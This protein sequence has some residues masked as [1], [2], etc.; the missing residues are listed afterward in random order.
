[1]KFSDFLKKFKKPHPK[2]DETSNWIKCPACGAI[3][4]YKEVQKQNNTCP[5]C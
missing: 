2:K 3:S 1:M 5:K 4:F